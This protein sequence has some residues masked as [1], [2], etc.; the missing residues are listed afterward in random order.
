MKR[1]HLQNM[2]LNSNVRF[3]VLKLRDSNE[4]EFMGMVVPN[5]VKEIPTNML[6]A[7]KKRIKGD[8]S[9]QVLKTSFDENV[10]GNRFRGRKYLQMVYTGIYQKCR[11][12]ERD[13]TYEDILN[14]TFN[15]YFV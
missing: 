14:S 8:G 13:L 12:A 15:S 3:E 10:D 5:R 2:D 7:Y 4:P 9:Y 1:L 11:S 6:S